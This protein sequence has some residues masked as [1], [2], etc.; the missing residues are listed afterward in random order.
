MIFLYY[1]QEADKPV[2]VARIF[3]IL[4]IVDDKI[5]LPIS[6]GEVIDDKRAGILVRKIK[7]FL[8]KTGCKTVI[9]SKF[10]K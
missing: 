2:I 1:I 6:S 5:I 3:N 10:L 8:D 4:E 7:K 9:L